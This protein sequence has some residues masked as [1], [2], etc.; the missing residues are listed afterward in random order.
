MSGFKRALLLICMLCKRLYKKVSF[1]LILLS[2]VVITAVMSVAVGG[3][4]NMLRVEIVG[5]ENSEEAQ[6]I[7][8]SLTSLDSVVKY[9]PRSS[10]EAE[11]MLATGKT[12]AI[13]DFGDDFD[14]AVMQF[15]K[16]GGYS[17]PINVTVR[18]NNV[19]AGLT[20]ERLYAE[21]YPIM[22]KNFYNSFLEENLGAGES[23]V[24]KYYDNQERFSGLI[25]M[26]YYNDSGTPD[27][28]NFLVTPL[29]GLLAMMIALCSL[30]CALYYMHDRDNGHMDAIPLNRRFMMQIAYVLSGTVNIAVFVLIALAICGL[31]GNV[32]TEI[33]VM[34]LYVIASVGFA[35]LMCGLLSKTSRLAPVVPI[36]MI[37][38][39]FVCPIFLTPNV[40]ILN[41]VFPAY[42]YLTAVFD[43]SHLPRMLAQTAVI[44]LLSFALSL[45]RKA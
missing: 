38:M 42:G 22:S 6:K 17:A 40:P 25:K 15:V 37:V 7:I 1:L 10:E 18:E 27:E 3:D 21:I 31:M 19:F 20:L 12:D 30:A 4:S 35:T 11:K 29:R 14:N 45:R 41:F 13:W 39:I 26:S 9:T 28:V 36:M 33:L 44:W 24:A 23:E 34:L 8:A 16:K 32:L 43:L 2:V 5:G